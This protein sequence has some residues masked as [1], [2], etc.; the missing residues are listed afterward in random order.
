MGE[1]C[2]D[3]IFLLGS[4]GLEAEV[5]SPLQVTPMFAHLYTEAARI[6]KSARFRVRFPGLEY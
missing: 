1:H 2:D 3:R 4:K 6:V 5:P